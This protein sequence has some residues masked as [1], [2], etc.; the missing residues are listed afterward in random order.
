[1]AAAA[2][3][4]LDLPGLARALSGQGLVDEDTGEISALLAPMVPGDRTLARYCEPSRT[5]VTVTP[6]VLPGHDDPAG[7]RRRL[8]LVR[9]ATEQRE[10]LERL[11][12]RRDQ[13]LRKALRQ[14]GIPA[15]LAA[16]AGIEARS[17]GFIAGV[18]MAHRHFVPA[19][20]QRW[21][22]V[23]VRLTFDRPVRGPLCVGG[24]RFYGL[25]LFTATDRAL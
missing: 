10:L 19:H 1:V 2:G 20:L 15:A 22:R 23:H 9:D 13:L 4:S 14:S 21:P 24:G 7:L 16:T 6:V 11:S 18:D 17:S 3:S 12:T 8:R 5:W 25:G